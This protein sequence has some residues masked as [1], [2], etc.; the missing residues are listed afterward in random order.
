MSVTPRPRRSR[1]RALVIEV[2]DDMRAHG[3]GMTLYYAQRIANAL[4]E[5]PV[6]TLEVLNSGRLVDNEPFSRRIE[7][8]AN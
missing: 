4:G 1:E 8:G 7:S 3:T 2:L 5:P 6:I